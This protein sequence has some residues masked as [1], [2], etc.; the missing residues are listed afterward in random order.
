MLDIRPAMPGTH[1]EQLEARGGRGGRLS[2]C[3]E[4][5]CHGHT[6]SLIDNIKPSKTLAAVLSNAA[7]L[8]VQASA[9][10]VQLQRAAQGN[11]QTCRPLSLAQ[12][13]RR[14]AKPGR[15]LA[16]GCR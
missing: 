9:G 8:L 12:S 6:L 15:R 11:Q 10:R 5:G 3:S 16:T 2:S 1:E 14:I 4:D 7:L 13:E